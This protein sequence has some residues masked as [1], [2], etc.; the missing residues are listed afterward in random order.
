M[1]FYFLL[2]NL[3]HRFYFLKNTDF[4]SQP[5]IICTVNE[6]LYTD[7]LNLEFS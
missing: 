7:N 3:L 5:R 6:E 1:D 2:K 4:N